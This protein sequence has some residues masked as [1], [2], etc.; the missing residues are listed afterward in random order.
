MAG[1]VALVVTTTGG[2]L[3][4]AAAT[5]QAAGQTTQSDYT[6]P[7]TGKRRVPPRSNPASGPPRHRA[8]PHDNT[9]APAPEKPTTENPKPKNRAHDKTPAS[10]S[11]RGAD[12][13]HIIRAPRSRFPHDRVRVEPGEGS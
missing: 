4:A 3:A 2:W 1:A 12:G 10:A 6:Q 9:C 13:M 11:H 7:D 8:R 5:D